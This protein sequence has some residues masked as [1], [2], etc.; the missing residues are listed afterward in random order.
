[1]QSLK[2]SL[3]FAASGLRQH[4]KHNVRCQAQVKPGS[5]S[6]KQNNII[7]EQKNIGKEI[8]V[9]NLQIEV[10][11]NESSKRREQLKAA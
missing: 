5:F 2:Y 11:F 8:E 7:E 6:S 1:M 3:P 4:F 9:E 10:K